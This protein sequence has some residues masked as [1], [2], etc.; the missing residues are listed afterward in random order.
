MATKIAA[1]ENEVFLLIVSKPQRKRHSI[2]YT[3]FHAVGTLVSNL[4][5]D[6]KPVS[7]A[8]F[9]PRSQAQFTLQNIYDTHVTEL[10]ISSSFS[11]SITDRSLTCHYHLQN[12]LT[13]FYPFHW[14]Q[15]IGIKNL[16]SQTLVLIFI[17]QVLVSEFSTNAKY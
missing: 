1:H 6:P 13:P 12:V 16:V 17:F 7:L 5:H 4:F 8:Y 14:K 15:K 9:T 10:Q 3:L 11:T 2:M